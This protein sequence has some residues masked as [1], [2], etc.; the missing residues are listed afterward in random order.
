MAAKRKPKTEDELFL[1]PSQSE[2]D[3][4]DFL[5]E[6]APQTSVVEIYRRK[7]DGSMPHVKRVGMDILRADLYGYL[8]DKFGNG[9]FILQFKN[10]QKQIVKNLTV[11][12]EGAALVG[13]PN[14]N[15]GGTFHEQLILALIAGNRPAPPPPPLDMGA[16]MTGIAA[17]IG[18]LKP[19]S[20]G[21]SPAAMLTAMATTFQ[22]LKPPQE[23]GVKQALDLIAAAKDLVPGGSSEDSWPGLIKEGI[24]TV[25]QVLQNR[26]QPNPPGIVERPAI[27]PGAV[28]VELPQHVPPQTTAASP[29][30]TSE[31]LLVQWI[32][33]Q[34]N[35]LKS[36]AR[37]GK[38]PEVWADHVVDNAEEP[39]NGA[40]LEALRRGYT[41]QHLLAFDPEIGQNPIL[42]GWF[43]TFYE[44]LLA[45]LSTDVDSTGAG[46]DAPDAP[47]NEKASS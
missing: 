23:G 14:G 9:K 46:G 18:A 10:A 12:V 33:Q 36:K 22:Q 26:Q 21:D 1:E 47:G 8:R 25:A 5:M 7:E 37:T 40:I 15:G 4:E 42:S 3:I 45:N 28:R 39:G 41:L 6:W 20:N 34:L 30:P 29:Q 27:P 11:D 17:L 19:A 24:S 35:Y 16:L 43:Q 38:D 44:T 31:E 2:L 13:V 32:T